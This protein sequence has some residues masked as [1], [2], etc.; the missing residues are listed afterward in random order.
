MAAE[1]D[2]GHE[3]RMAEA[4]A[5]AAKNSELE[6]EFLERFFAMGDKEDLSRYSATEIAA[7]THHSFERFA[8]SFDGKH[9][10]ELTDP[11]FAKDKNAL[12]NQITVIELHN[13]N[14]PFLVDSIMGELQNAGLEIHLV[15][16]PVL[17][18]ER[19]EKG[20]LVGLFD[21]LDVQ[22]NPK[23]RRESLIHVHVSRLSSEESRAE[24]LGNIDKLLDDVDSVVDDWKSM[25]LRLEETIAIYKITPPPLQQ[26]EID[27]TVE[28][29]RWLVN[30][31]FTLLGMREYAF[32]GSTEEGE[33]TR[34]QRPGLG[35]LRDPDVRVLRRGDQMVTMTPE[36]KEFLMRPEP[37]IITKA[38]VKTNVHRRTYMDYIG[39]KLYGDHG[40]LTGELR[41]VGLFTSTAYNRS[42]TNI[43]FLRRKV[44]NTLEAAAVD[45][46]GHSGKALLNV[47]EGYPRDELF[48]VDMETL[49]TNSQE[50]L[51]LHQRPRVRILSRVDKFDR[52]VSIL[53]YVPRDRYNTSIRVRIGDYLH[54]VYD[55]RLS[56]VYPDFPDGPLAR[57]H[58][59]IGRSEG[60]TPNPSRTELENAVNTIVR[61][62][63]DGLMQ[64]VRDTHKLSKAS[65]LIN[66]YCEAFSYAYR[67]TFE[68]E[69]A[70][71][72]ISIM[73]GMTGSTS[74]AIQFYRKEDQNEKHRI[75]LKIFHKDTPIPLSERVPI[76]ENMGF[77]VI[78]ERSYDVTPLD[79]ESTYWM[80]D[81]DI[82]RATGEPIDIKAL[83]D[84]LHDCFL[85][86]WNGNAENDGYNRL[87]IAAGLPWR[88]ITILRT[89][90]R[91]LRQIRIPY[92]QDY[93]WDTLNSY[94]DLAAIL[95]DLFHA[96]FDPDHKKREAECT[97]LENGILTALEQVANLDDDRI[98]R[99]FLTVI[100]ASLRTNFYQRME[101]GDFKPGLSVKLD[102]RAIDDMPEPK[103]FREIFVYS[104]RVEGL[105]LRFGMVARGG[106]R[107]SDR[108]QDFRTEVLGLVK[109]QQVKNAVIVPVGSKGGFVPKH[110]PTEGGREAFMAE[111]ITCYKLFISSLLDVT[112]NL[113]GQE[114]LPPL[115]VIRHDEDDPYL[116]VAADKGTATFS[117]IANSISEDR[118]YWL[119]DAF[120][121]G[122]SA[123]YD[124]KK[125]GITARGAWEAV[126]R[127][128][129]EMD[130]DIQTEPFT[131][132]GVGDMSGDVFGNGMLLSKETRLI[133]AFDHRDIFIDPDPDPETSWEERKRVF[134][135][136][137]SSWRDYDEKLISKGGGIFSRKEK[138]IKLSKEI[139]TV[140]GMKKASVTPQELMKAILMAP[141]DLLWFG[142][143]G[144]YIRASS[145]SDADADD[146]ANDAIRVT[147][148]D[149]RVKVLG[150]GANLGVTQRARIE[151]NHLGGRSNSDAIDNSAGVNSSDMEVNIKIAL[152]T[153][154]REQRLDIKARNK[155]LAS[156]TDNVANLV[157]RNN[158]LQTLSISLTE[159][160]A[161]EDFG[162][163]IRLMERLED[164]GELDR[165]VEFLPDKEALTEM[166][167]KDQTFTRAEIGVL[168]AYAKN[169]L[170]DSL[171]ESSLPDDPYLEQELVR[172]FPDKMQ[173]PY[174]DEIASH[175]LRREIIS[176][177]VTNSMINRGGA[178]L[179]PRI[180]DKTGA[181][182]A[183]IARAYVAVRE[184]FD[185]RGLHDAIDGLDN[186]VNGEVQ[187]E[188]YQEV[189]QLA[190]TE[191][192][193][194]M[195]NV[196][197]S[198]S[199]NDTVALYRKG[200]TELST[201]IDKFL[202]PYLSQRLKEETD[203]YVE[204]NVPEKLAARIAH[205]PLI[206]RIPDI[207]QVA[208]QAGKSH[209]QAAET[210][211]AV[212]GH[213]K[214]G[215][216]DA[217]AESLDVMDYYEGLALDRVR[218]SLSAAHSQMTV[219]VLAL[220][221]DKDNGLES[222]LEQEG[223]AV[224]RTLKSVDTITSSDSLSVS[225]LAVAAGLLSD[226]ARD[227]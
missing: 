158:Y 30:N 110:L 44:K 181:T 79:G 192:L 121:S 18:L 4:K 13:I 24:L 171:L 17:N 227:V 159:R 153:A 198:N 225:K 164:A 100:R 49:L 177:A 202:P 204:H 40:E 112:D 51:R 9:R 179:V 20:E 94:P 183:D 63:A 108:P 6:A 206:A 69:I 19:S 194:F 68:P 207:V 109:A 54:K 16:H 133:A 117:D 47:L 42:A 64:A 12:L 185:M 161:M 138:S 31:N 2:T 96:R 59:I 128:F 221:T 214:I 111:G 195:R 86:V 170:Y 23:I 102:P 226:L 52:F 222:W 34:S 148:K 116:V 103:P 150:E 91:Y 130:R 43:P 95:V 132:V 122:G 144:T 45:P 220:A 119:G 193:W 83:A 1:K 5:L 205:L 114:T 201:K 104:P 97:R 143:I 182:S 191:I 33:L 15:L 184:S 66:R 118:E 224:D 72:D 56:A 58:F 190:L 25:L 186:E 84:K 38:N 57:V 217:L 219:S 200:I 199:I 166:R 162:Y 90:S 99:K 140:L 139:Q 189:Q 216:I 35:L 55:G 218:D 176:T 70:L 124:H 37:L 89:I 92:D 120:A 154:V 215:R 113:D 167:K 3:K 36:I 26:D 160:R 101:N 123:G 134:D 50:I 145:E 169:T 11:T 136:G 178:T 7:I 22:T 151:F 81:M 73:E 82:E 129:R 67:D 46:S 87:T 48:Q 187:L 29:L 32:D 210:Y 156:M 173:A 10:V 149:L 208:D 174:A 71:H 75:T 98:L 80:H 78:D 115:D 53:V 65:T 137:R 14:K 211:F 165:N 197:S 131:V 223:A 157:L 152:G 146:R 126:K 168:L 107:W 163:Q 175:R 93:M 61:T 74:T 127:H 135:L 125:M 147:P 41:I 60:K 62:W 209:E 203:R 155:L 142:G 39:I 180:A 76:L 196:P 8:A 213:F 77:R 88:D 105:H 28:F 21:R 106:L 85:A 172:Y 212:A 141:A 188:L 27:E